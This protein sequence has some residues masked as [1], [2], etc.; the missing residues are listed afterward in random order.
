VIA[1][2]KPD[3]GALVSK[4]LRSPAGRR[5]AI[6]LLGTLALAILS[7]LP[8]AAPYRAHIDT[9]PAASAPWLDRLNTWRANAGIPTLTEDTTWSQGDYNHSLY[10]VK[11]N[12]V[13]HYETPGVPYYTAAGDTAARN[14]NIQVSSTTGTTDDQAIDWWMGAPFHAMG[15]MDPRLTTTGFGSYRDTTTSPWQE[16]GTLD[17]LRGNSFSGG[18][19]PVYFPGDGTT[20]PLTTYSGNEFPDPLQACSGYSVPTGL[21]VFIQVGGNVATTAGSVHSFTGNGA[22]LAHCVIDSSNPAVGSSLTSRGGVIVIPRLPLVN[23]VTYVVSLTVNGLPYSWS[24]TVGAFNSVNP[25]ACTSASIAPNV[26]SPQTSGATITFTATATHCTTPQFEFFL[27]PPGGSWNAQTAG[28]G[29]NTWAWNTTGMAPGVYGVGVWARQTGAFNRYDSYWLGT[30]TLSNVTCTAATLS[31]PTVSPQAA[32]A[33][34]TFTAAATRCPSAQYRFWMVPHGGVWTMQRDYGAATWT[35][36]TA[37]LAPGTYQLGVWARQ[38]GSTNAYDA[39]G[40]TTFAIGAGNCISAGLSPSLATP[41]APG[42]TVLFTASAN[43]CTTALYQ[44]W[45]LSPGGGWTVKQPYSAVTTWSW[46]SSGMPLGTYQVGVWA[47]ASAS[48]ASYDA[49]FIGTYQLD[50]SPCTSASISANPASPQAPGTT[51]TLTATSTDC[52][53]PTYRFWELPPPATTWS[54]TQPYGP[55]T[56]F[57]W[58]T[59]GLAPGPYRIGVWAKQNGSANSYDSYGIITFWVGS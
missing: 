27:Q 56:T 36:N 51:I 26:A 9:V 21:P 6:S 52:A 20:E 38:P 19:Y 24:F 43:T 13:T 57:S 31:T 3:S 2:S 15:M 1:V 44:F 22:A 11:N 58:N 54:V 35:W 41:Q 49:F 18:K 53:V 23:G 45:M 42:A 25:L 40:F 16:G 50:V 10:M 4:A 46:N 30:F 59:T 34:I 55:A 8:V 29:A 12:L 37:G 28:F 33:V 48:A 5:L 14:G 39:Y 7:S 17:T 47:K 32:G